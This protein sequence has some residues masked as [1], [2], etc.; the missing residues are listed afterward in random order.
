MITNESENIEDSDQA[1]VLEKIELHEAEEPVLLSLEDIEIQTFL[2]PEE[3]VQGRDRE[4]H[5]EPQDVLEHA[6][7]ED[8]VQHA[9]IETDDTQIQFDPEYEQ[10]VSGNDPEEINVSSSDEV[11]HGADEPAERTE[12]ILEQKVD[13]PEFVEA[14]VSSIEEII[15]VIEIQTEAHETTAEPILY[16][17]FPEQTEQPAKHTILTEN[18]IPHEEEQL[19]QP[20]EEIQHALDPQE[21]Q[22]PQKHKLRLLPITERYFKQLVEQI[23]GIQDLLQELSSIKNIDFEGLFDR[24]FDASNEVTPE[25]L[26]NDNAGQHDDTVILLWY[27]LTILRVLGVAIMVLPSGTY[28]KQKANSTKCPVCST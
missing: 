5:Q 8:F 4:P 20:D 25:E 13:A 22:E 28:Q 11:S 10:D 9:M 24:V 14:A 17:I 7:T 21:D 6:E 18:L 1:P 26:R 2:Q 23:F 16:M 27:V 3:P 12:R 19:V 15:P